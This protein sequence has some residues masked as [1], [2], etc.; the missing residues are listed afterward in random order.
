MVIHSGSIF[1]LLAFPVTLASV[2]GLFA[3]LV[4]LVTRRFRMAAKVLAVSVGGWAAYVG[5]VTAISLLAPQR[6]IDIGNSYCW[7]N[8]CMGIEKVNTAPRG[9]E[10]VYSVDVRIFDA[11]ERVKTSIKGASVYLMDE[12]GRRFPLVRDPS[13]I[14]FDTPLD[15]AQSLRTTMTFAAAADASHLSLT[16]DAPLP[17]P[18]P[19]WW[20]CFGVFAD[21]HFG[22]ESLSH[23]PTLLRV[24]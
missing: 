19:W 11:D 10:I 21:L 2:I 24:L 5:S 6:I 23:K 8:W 22:Y 20:R 17:D 4:L 16:G 12:R 1:S 7:D 3:F 14:P 15:P 9:Q 18:I 13:V